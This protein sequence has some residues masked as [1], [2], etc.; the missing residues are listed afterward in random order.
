[1]LIVDTDAN[2]R[3]VGTGMPSLSVIF[4]NNGFLI[5]SSFSSEGSGS[6]SM[7]P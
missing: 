3:W 6:S 5:G 1:M 4:E 2:I 7:G